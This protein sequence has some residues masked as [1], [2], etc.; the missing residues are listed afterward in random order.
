M[1]AA[2]LDFKDLVV[3]ITGAGGG[4]GRAYSLFFGSRGAKVVVNDVAL[5]PAQK[6]VDE[7]VKAGGQAVPAVGSVTE[8]Q[9]VVDQAVK[10]FGT[11][12]VVIN[13]AGILRDKSFRKMTD[14]E[15][16]IIV[17]V[18]LTGAFSI[19]KA[20][21][22]LFRAQ[23]FGRVINTASPAG[24]YGNGGQVNYSAAKMGLVAF[25]RTLA[26][27]GVKYNIKS[28]TIVPLAAS[29]MT[30]TVMPPDFLKALQPEWIAPLVGILTSKNGPDVTGRIFE[31][32]AGFFSEVRWERTKGVIY[33]TDDSFTVEAVEA[34]WKEVQD[35]TNA[36]HPTDALPQDMLAVIEAQPKLPKNP[37]GAP[38]SFKGQT[39]I[40]T[41]AGAGLG[42]AYAL[43]YGKLGANVVINDV[44]AENANKVVEEVKALGA[45]A[46]AAVSSA[47]DGE[48][49]VKT[50]IDAFGKV[51]V[52]VANAGI[53]RDKAF[54]N[55]TQQQWD[56]VLAVH[57]RGT[58]KCAKAVW[59]YFHDQ[60]YGR[61]IV[62]ASP[63]GIY[64]AHGQVNYGTAK[65]ALIGFTKA[66]AVEG[67][68]SNIFVNSI[69]PR[70]GTAMTET[71]WTKEMVAIFKPDFVAP[72]VAYLSSD[73]YN[74]TAG[75]YEVFGGYVAQV[76]WERSYGA[77]FPNN[78]IATP[79]Q[80][81]ARWPEITKFDDR[82]TH[83]TSPA[84]SFQQLMAN[85]DNVEEDSAGGDQDYVD[86]ED[87]EVV[88]E[89]KRNSK[90][91]SEFTYTNRD[92]I[93]YNLGI[94]AKAKELDW[95]YE[96]ADNFGAL[97]TFGVIP[98]FEAQAGLSFDFVPNF[99]PATLLHGEQYL[100]IKAPIPTE[101]TLVST[102]RLREVL[103]KG[104]AAAVTSVVET[105]DKATGDLIFVNE[106]T[107]FL[108]GSGGF[109][110]KK[111][112]SDRGASTAANVPPKRAPDAVVEEKTSEDQ[113]A[114]YRLS[115]DYNPLHIDPS[116]S[117][118][119]GFPKPILHGLCSFGIAGKHVLK[120]FGPYEDIKVR[121]AGVVIPGETLVTEMWKE[122]DK[123]IFNVKVKE[124]NAVAISNAAV[125]L[126]PGA[127]LKSK[128]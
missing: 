54:V 38:I 6:V 23:K 27:E 33:K 126:A 39:V 40:I 127:S 105:R 89:A 15:F 61:I 109:G 29:P 80:V 26:K 123:V 96:N 50:A 97:P 87:P 86:P 32:G 116:F 100:A 74:Q 14:A 90:T 7:I 24:L 68:K 52:L 36:E 75:L 70:A 16:D 11:V 59:P 42:R 65:A 4:I 117:K 107:V 103:D 125:T 72:V 84:E 25:S 53:L 44:S 13:N 69:A 122:G 20:V 17:A 104:K 118:I 43:L 63:N 111:T 12:H 22:P 71:V 115:G 101:G 93:L 77:T 57:L 73:K 19:T 98:Q 5:A 48:G 41:G 1:A 55:M 66:L 46:V 95:T 8:G 47:E 83:P 3:L 9:L 21:W 119:G 60:K 112:G 78:H 94:G 120:T 128:L 35:F 56:Q 82:S 81:L 110:G 102:V 99:N 30:E 121:F 88:K 28:N 124:R 85:F 2:P 31:V 51:H 76:R 108:R 10:A 113:A 67:K 79:E 49:I 18:H 34:R 37:Q 64:G 106:G 45:K 92:V 114:L 91:E 62:T 58:Y